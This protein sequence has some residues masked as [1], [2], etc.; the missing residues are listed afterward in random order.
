V[1]EYNATSYSEGLARATVS[2][3]VRAQ[4]IQT[5]GFPAAPYIENIGVYPD[6]AADYM[7]VDNLMTGGQTFVTGFTT[8]ISNL[9]TNGHP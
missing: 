7:T 5:P 4:P 6:V 3:G 2:I 9:I 8:V 1:V